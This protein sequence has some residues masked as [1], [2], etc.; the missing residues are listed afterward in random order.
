MSALQSLITLVRRN[1]T[2]RAALADLRRLSAEQLSDI[3]LAPDGL[4]DVVA[5]MMTQAER[6]SAAAG[7]RARHGVSALAPGI[8]QGRG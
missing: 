1:Q 3:G 7:G 2:R 4:G 6:R 5:S 8:L